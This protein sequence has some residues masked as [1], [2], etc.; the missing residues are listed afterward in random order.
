MQTT[1]AVHFNGYIEG[2]ASLESSRDKG[3]PF[4]FKLGQ[5]K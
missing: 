5:G 2:G 4:K 3:V 1:V